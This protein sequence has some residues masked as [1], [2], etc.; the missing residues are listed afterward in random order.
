MF[1]SQLRL[2]N[3]RCLT[4]TNVDF[5]KLTILTGANNSG[6]SSV[7]YGLLA[8]LQSEKFPVFCSPNGEYVELGD[9]G[10]L[11]RGHNRSSEM[12]IGMDLERDASHKVHIDGT[13]K[14]DPHS[15]MPIM[16]AIQSAVGFFEIDITKQRD[17]RAKYRI[18]PKAHRVVPSMST[19]N[20]EL[21]KSL[22]AF[23]RSI[24]AQMKREDRRRKTKGRPSVNPF[25][26]WEN[27][28]ERTGG[29]TFARPQELISN[30][31]LQND[32]WAAL[33]IRDITSAVRE[34]MNQFNYIS[35]FRNA[36]QR[37]YYEISKS[38]LK[39]GKYGEYY[40]NQISEWGHS[41]STKLE[42]LNSHLRKIGLA[43]SVRASRMK[44][45]RFEI[46]GK[47]YS[48]SP[49]ASLMD[50]GFGVSQLLPLLVADLQLPN[51]STLAVS[52]PET[53]LHPSVQAN[54]ANY[55]VDK[56]TTKNKRFI[57]ETHS[58]Y[59][60][61]RVRLLIVQEVLKPED[62]SVVY[63]RNVGQSSD[64]HKIQFTPK[65]TIEGAPPD[66]FETYMMD[67]MNIALNA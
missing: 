60:L 9:F 61:N 15:R 64:V 52:Q 35:S 14:E 33:G 18:V 21:M 55:F 65:G 42:Q 44:G 29:F 23:M 38:D 46:V 31:K 56:I 3:F 45:G 20:A 67:V 5:S 66:F 63:L 16:N 19:A 40:I 17:Y 47:A 36:P 24:E 41:K 26:G 37:T 10:E 13:F 50:L 8:A 7:L 49:I 4:K 12:G 58:E 53:H 59:F 1:V 22:E 39:V 27:E 30:L 43:K 6:K 51:E 57:V 54:L 48:R 34:L 32:Y 25:Q 28:S 62:I 2:K 11:V